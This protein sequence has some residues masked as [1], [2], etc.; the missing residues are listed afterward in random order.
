MLNAQADLEVVAQANDGEQAVERALTE[1]IDLAILDI[2]MPRKT[3]LRPR[4][5]SRT[6]GPRC[7]C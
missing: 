7:A 4:A 2:S 3:G 5:R 6:A 1:D